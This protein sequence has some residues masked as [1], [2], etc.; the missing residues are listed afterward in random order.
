MLALRF[1]YSQTGRE[2]VADGGRRP[3][4]QATV[5]LDTQIASAVN[6]GRE[7]LC[8][9]V[10]GEKGG[11]VSDGE[12]GGDDATCTGQVVQKTARGTVGCVHGAQEA[13]CF[14]EKLPDSRS[15]EL[16]EEGTSVNGPEMADITHP[17]QL[18]GDD[19]ETR[20]LLQ[21]ETCW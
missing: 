19:G 8:H 9:T 3:S 7:R 21:V 4:N 14:W 2:L 17:V 12:R 5:Q 20:R 1:P 6:G 10:C 15:L 13:P 18:F 11:N 16:S